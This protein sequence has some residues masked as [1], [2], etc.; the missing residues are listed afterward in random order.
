VLLLLLL[1]ISFK[2]KTNEIDFSKAK[3]YFKRKLKRKKRDNFKLECVALL[4]GG[5][6]CILN[7]RYDVDDKFIIV[8]L[9]RREKNDAMVMMMMMMMMI[10]I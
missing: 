6:G 3:K 5:F 9:N 2:P 7:V 1:F 4:F 10:E 8:V